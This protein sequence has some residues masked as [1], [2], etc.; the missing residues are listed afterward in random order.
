MSFHV[1]YD[2]IENVCLSQKEVSFIRC[3]H[4]LEVYYNGVRS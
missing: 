1:S 3:E 4:P 2:S